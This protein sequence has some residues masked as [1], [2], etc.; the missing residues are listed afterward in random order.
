MDQWQLFSHSCTMNCYTKYKC[1]ESIC[2]VSCK[3]TTSHLNY[4]YIKHF[5]WASFHRP[6]FLFLMQHLATVVLIGM[7]GD[8]RNGVLQKGST[9]YDDEALLLLGDFMIGPQQFPMLLPRV[10]LQSGPEM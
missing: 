2:T 1:V 10:I 9:L 6:V 4:A 8:V 5:F 3:T 7:K